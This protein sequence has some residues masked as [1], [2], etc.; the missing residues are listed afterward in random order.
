MNFIKYD[1]NNWERLDL[2]NHFSKNVKCSFNMTK[3]L[4]ITNIVNIH[5][6]L[7]IKFYPIM[8]Y[9]ISKTINSIKEL[10]TDIDSIG[11]IGYYSFSNP[12]YTIF[13]DEKKIFYNTYTSYNKDFNIFYDEYIKD[14]KA[15]L[16]EKKLNN[17][18]EIPNL[19]SISSI[20]WVDY[21]SFQIQVSEDYL[22]P[23]ITF[24]K[25]QN[26]NGIYEIPLSIRV[27]HST[28]DG[29]HIGLFYNKLQENINLFNKKE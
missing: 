24:G 19:I 15:V 17:K 14:I 25:F 6:S 26:N 2:F 13:D 16:S 12:S 22:L 10:R 20:C 1:L 29:Y 9:L 18:K 7:N 8:I 23:I 3:K 4:D 28:A 5:K 21:E 11:N 27:N